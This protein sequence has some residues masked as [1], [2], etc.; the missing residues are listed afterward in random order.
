M[1]LDGSIH[2]DNDIM[3][4]DTE[5][6]EEERARRA[7]MDALKQSAPP[8]PTTTTTSLDDAQV[9]TDAAAASAYETKSEVESEKERWED[10]VKQLSLEADRLRKQT[11]V[12][13]D[14]GRIYNDDEGGVMDEAERT[15]AALTAAPDALDLLQEMNKKKELRAVDHK[16]IEYLP[17]RKNLYIVPQSLARLTPME[18]AE[19]RA[20]L[21]VK[22][23]GKGAPAPVSKFSEAGLSER[24][25][26]VLADKN[27]VDPFPVQ[28]QCLPCI[29][30]GRDVIGIAK[31]GSG[32]TLAFVLP[33][34]RQ[35]LDQ[36]SHWDDLGSGS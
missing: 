12:A 11:N 14:V 10:D 1:D 23:R 16:S 24:I 3:E 36:R 34:L 21:G 9:S 20:K 25:M 35:I 7:F 18:V 33:M 13:I 4:P 27:I 6:E 32:K 15:L 31:T 22:V 28:A 30:A 5:D 8:P 2:P 19:R 17:V 26:S 29:M